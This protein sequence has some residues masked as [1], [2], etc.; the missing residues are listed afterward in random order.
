[1]NALDRI[2]AVEAQRPEDTAQPEDTPSTHP[3][4]EGTGQ[5]PT[6]AWHRTTVSVDKMAEDLR[7]ALLG[8]MNEE[9]AR[10]FRVDEYDGQFAQTLKRFSLAFVSICSPLNELFPDDTDLTYPGPKG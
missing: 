1:M 7:D 9:I 5:D 10:L 2:T 8:G 6:G 4:S 3:N